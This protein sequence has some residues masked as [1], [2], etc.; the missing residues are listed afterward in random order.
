MDAPQEAT[1]GG[2]AC[3]RGPRANCATTSRRAT[4]ETWPRAVGVFRSTQPT[5]TLRV[6]RSGIPR[7][8]GNVEARRVSCA[9]AR[10][11]VTLAPRT[12]V[13]L[14]HEVEIVGQ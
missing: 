7:G 12:H 2:P 5:E 14:Q 8:G 13:E 4:V 11:A 10:R 1:R 6:A 3:A 9:C